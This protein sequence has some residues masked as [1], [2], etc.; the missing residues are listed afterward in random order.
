M[1]F[2]L[3]YKR[4]ACRLGRSLAIDT[5]LCFQKAVASLCAEL[6]TARKIRI[7]RH[8][9]AQ[10][11]ALVLMLLVHLDTLI[12]A[13]LKRISDQNIEV[14]NGTISICSFLVARPCSKTVLREVAPQRRMVSSWGFKGAAIVCETVCSRFDGGW[15]RRGCRSGSLGV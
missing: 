15:T 14:V 13:C 8:S 5:F 1:R 6:N 2:G 10:W 4:G 7:I 11:R 9:L 3:E 12:H